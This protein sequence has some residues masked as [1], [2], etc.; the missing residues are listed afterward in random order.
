MPIRFIATLL[1]TMVSLQAQSDTFTP[2]H[3]CTKPFKPIQFSS[4][5][6]VQI[7]LNQ[8]DAY[9]RCINNF[10]QEQE[11]AIRRHREAT[12]NAINEWNRFVSLELN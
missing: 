10:I 5:M 7:F 3:Y 8:V 12:Q 6:E 1:I 4:D 11:E 9:E 2:S